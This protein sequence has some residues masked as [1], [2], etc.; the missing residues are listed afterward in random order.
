LGLSEVEIA[1]L[2]SEEVIK[3]EAVQYFDWWRGWD[4]TEEEFDEK[5]YEQTPSFVL[6]NRNKLGI[7]LDLTS[8]DG[9]KLLKR[10]VKISISPR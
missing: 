9:V 10:L 7:T 8:A 3:V 2:K 4:L 5:M 1:Q 6:M